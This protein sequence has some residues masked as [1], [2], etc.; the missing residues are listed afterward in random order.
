MGLAHSPS[1]VID[2]LVH[3]LEACKVD[4]TTPQTIINPIVGSTWTANNFSIGNSTFLKTFLSNTDGSGAGSSFLQVSPNSALTTGSITFI[5]W[6]NLKNIPLNVGGNNNWRGL[7]CTNTSGTAGSPLTMVLEQSSLINFSTTHE[8]IYRR[9]LNNS[10]TP[11]SV[12]S[13]G[14]Q[15]VSYT[16]DKS[17]GNASCYKNNS[18]ILSGPMTANTGN[19]TPTTPGLA[20]SYTNY[21]SGGTETGF[22]IYGGTNTGANP[23]GNG[24]CPGEVSNIMIY[25]RALNTSEIQQNFNALRGRF[26]I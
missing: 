26:G 1:I 2:G 19:G 4:G 17:S 12:D 18:L 8:D 14:W 5:I 16:Y 3:L 24:M 20:L 22:R 9:Y 25:N 23:S 13:N 7:L 10:F 11:I 15:M 21:T 6:L